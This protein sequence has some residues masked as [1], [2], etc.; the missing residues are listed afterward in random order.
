[1]RRKCLLI[2]D[3]RVVGQVVSRALVAQDVDV[4]WSVSFEQAR[5]HFSAEK[6]HVV[7]LDLMLPGA[8]GA[9]GVRAVRATWPAASV[10]AMTA[11]D[12]A[13]PPKA[14]LAEACAAGAGYLLGKPF[15]PQQLIDTVVDA[16]EDAIHAPLK[17]HVLVVEDSRTV[18]AFV[19][20]ALRDGHYRTSLSFSVEDALDSLLLPLVDV[21][22]TDI[23]MAGVG[24]LEGVMRFRKDW[25]R[26]GVVAM[27]GGLEQGGEGANALKAAL[28]VG[29]HVA[30][31]KPFT[32]Q[33]LL[34]AIETARARAL[35]H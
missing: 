27:S 33:A 21:V 2:E 30:L 16:A 13:R 14:M 19:K 35:P 34:E 26:L 32:P 24:G 9:A 28:K 15:S 12:G 20:R 29:A 11:G 23:F 17:G 8:S 7:L 1:M 3:S 4:L 31:Q 6:P 22:V 18:Q 10:V 25:P 5:D